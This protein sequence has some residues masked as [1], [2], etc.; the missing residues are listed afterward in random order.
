[1]TDSEQI[2][3]LIRNWAALSTAETWRPWWPG[4]PPTS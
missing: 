3:T 2:E 4:T 1:M